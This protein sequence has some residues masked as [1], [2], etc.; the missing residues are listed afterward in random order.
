M[1]INEIRLEWVIGIA[2]ILLVLALVGIVIVAVQP[3]IA[4]QNAAESQTVSGDGVY[5]WD[6]SPNAVIFRADIVGGQ[7]P[8]HVRVSEVPRCTVYGDNRVVWVNELGEFNTETLF[9]VVPEARL[10]QFIDYVVVNETLYAYPLPPPA[11]PVEGA[12]IEPSPVL[13]TLTLNIGGQAFT[14]DSRT[15]FPDDGFFTRIL[16]S[17]RQISGTPILFQPQ[18]GYINASAIALN[19]ANVSFAWDSARYGVSLADI[20]AGE[21]PRWVEGEAVQELWQILRTQPSSVSFD[22]ETANGLQR[23]VVSLQIPNVSRDAPPAPAS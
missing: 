4:S 6:R 3:F 23:F 14:T 21:S 15:V 7:L 2:A 11:T 13:E 5:L 1:R 22:E 20:A 8:D 16:D 9:D 18:A 10:R 19:S 17:C 12:I